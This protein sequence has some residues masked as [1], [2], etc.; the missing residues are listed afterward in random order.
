MTLVA[1]LVRKV[2]SSIAESPPPTTTSSRSRKKKPSQVAQ[3]ETPRPRYWRS[4][5]SPSILALAPVEMMSALPVYSSSSTQARNGGPARSTL[6]A[7]ARMNSAPKRSACSRILPISSG[8]RIPV[9]KP[10]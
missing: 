7:S 6:V 5:G 9:G 4:P 1:N 10:G 8:P 2:A 3:V